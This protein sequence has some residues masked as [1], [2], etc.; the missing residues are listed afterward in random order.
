MLT[1]PN[2]NNRPIFSAKEI[3]DFYLQKSYL[4]FPHE[5]EVGRISVPATISWYDPLVDWIKPVWNSFE[6]EVLRPQYDGDSLHNLIKNSVK[7]KRLH[8]TL[9]NVI[10]P[11]FDIKNLQPVTFS[12]LKAKRDESEDAL[13]SDICIG[14]SAAPYYLP[15]YYF[16]NNSSKISK[17]FNLIDGGVA[18]N[19]P[20]LFQL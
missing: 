7:D 8:E 13:Q 16:E 12:T 4:I 9:T 15:A 6:K 20:V 5:S 19:N 11:T 1:T 14:T 10:I 17:S 2:E 18:A 3:I